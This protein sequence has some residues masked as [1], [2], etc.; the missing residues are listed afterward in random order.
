MK[1]FMFTM[2]I[3]IVALFWCFFIINKM[4]T[5]DAI[6]KPMNRV[7]IECQGGY[8]FAWI[9]GYLGKDVELVQ[10]Y[11]PMSDFN[12]NPTPVRCRE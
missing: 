8:L 12:A 7:N 3:S 2:A 10:V 5:G 6:A 1:T 9:D 11:K 4:E